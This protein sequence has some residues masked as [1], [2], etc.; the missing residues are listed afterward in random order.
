MPA[1]NNKRGQGLL[2]QITLNF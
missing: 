2:L 1:L